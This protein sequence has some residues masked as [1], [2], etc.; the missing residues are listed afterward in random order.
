MSTQVE[1]STPQY[2]DGGVPIYEDNTRGDFELR[3]G[4]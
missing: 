4:H 2:S 1:F 3:D